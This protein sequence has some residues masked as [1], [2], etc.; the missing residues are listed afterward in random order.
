MRPSPLGYNEIVKLCG[1]PVPLIREDGTVSP[2]WEARMVSVKMPAPLQLGW[3][4]AF[5]RSARVH[6]AI[7]AEVDETF[8]LLSEAGLW[9]RF[10]TYDG[11]YEWR[12]QRGDRKKLSTHSFGLALDFDED[13]NKQGRA[14]GDM[15][16]EIVKVFE[17]CGWTWGGRF[18]GARV[19]SMHFQFA[20]GY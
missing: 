8:R 17:A 4:P 11:G 6:T 18:A 2:F 14:D 9:S 15:P 20:R 16:V 5:A 10:R 3:Q 7:A 1:D 13:T 12:R 19:D